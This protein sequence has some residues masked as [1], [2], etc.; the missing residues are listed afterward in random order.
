MRQLTA[1]DAS[2]NGELI[3]LAVAQAAADLSSTGKARCAPDD[4]LG[5]PRALW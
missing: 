4:R 5:Y 3:A 2:P 1:L